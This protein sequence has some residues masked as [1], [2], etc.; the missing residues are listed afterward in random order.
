MATQIKYLNNKNIQVLKKNTL[1][2]AK[3]FRDTTKNCTWECL[4]CPEPVTEDGYINLVFRCAPVW[5][6]FYIPSA[7]FVDERT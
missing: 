3:C 5:L 7:N 2:A 1:T 6:Q 4:L